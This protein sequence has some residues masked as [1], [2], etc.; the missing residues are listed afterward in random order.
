MGTLAGVS[1]FSLLDE[2]LQ[3]HQNAHDP[4]DTIACALLGENGQ[5]VTAGHLALRHTTH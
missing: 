4:H 3:S 2:A 5:A 1:A